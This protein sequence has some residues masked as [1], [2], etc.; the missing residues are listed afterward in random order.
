MAPSGAGEGVAPNESAALE[1]CRGNEFQH[2]LLQARTVAQN[3]RFI[4]PK[5]A[6]AMLYPGLKMIL[7]PAPGRLC[8]WT[9]R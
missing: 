5:T 7:S 8:V 1:L 2:S 9:H 3:R 6:G 4:R